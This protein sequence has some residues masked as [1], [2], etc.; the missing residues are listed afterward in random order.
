MR[1]V[2]HGVWLCSLTIL[3]LV[4]AACGGGADS[5][6]MGNESVVLEGVTGEGIVTRISGI[7][8]PDGDQP[9]DVGGVTFDIQH[10]DRLIN[11]KVSIELFTAGDETSP[12]G[13]TPGNEVISLVPG[14]YSAKLVYRQSKAT[15]FEGSIAGVQVHAGRTAKYKVKVE[16]PIGFLNLKFYND[17]VD[18]RKKVTYTLYP[19]TEGDD[20]PVRGE[21]LLAGQSAEEA[22]AVPEG[23]YDVLA[24]YQETDNLQREA[25][26]EGL[27]VEGGMSQLVKEYDFA[28]T[29]HGFILH[30]KNFGE[31]VSDKSTVYFY[32]PGS[33]VEFAVASDQG[34]AGKLLVIKPGRYDVR[35]VYQPS[36]E[37]VTWGDK[38]IPNVEI[39]ERKDA[40]EPVA[41]EGEG[42]AEGAESTPEPAKDAAAEEPAAGAEEGTEA[43][44]AEEESQL[45]V[46]E[47]DLEKEL[48]LLDV[49]VTYGGED[50]SEKAIMRV[51][52]AGADKV[53]ASAVI[54]ITG[55]SKHIIPAQKYDIHIKY[56][57]ADLKGEL[58]FED[59]TIAHGE[60]WTQEA[61]LR[62]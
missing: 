8:K 13:K 35:V 4:F 9:P 39:A 43:P 46:M 21:P 20:G 6:G 52:Y 27:A 32:R 31:D 26:L 2:P 48:G 38:T 24:V 41:G 62:P 34:P 22:L 58:W 10:V 11:N 55:I 25:W 42:E 54:D 60:T 1:R 56:A 57:Q 36:A 28:V 29:L 15:R 51:I 61:E 40:E 19:V 14:T 50:V 44:A 37:Q 23:V 17:E 3:L 16:A 18:V 45:H 49:V 5:E 47:V 59:V 7:S 12:A 53:A 33:N 30:A